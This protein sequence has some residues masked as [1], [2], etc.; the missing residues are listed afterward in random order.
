MKKLLISILL[1]PLLLLFAGCP[2]NTSFPLSQPGSEKINKALLGTWMNANPDSAEGDV[3]GVKISE[4]DKYTYTVE[5]LRKGAMYMADDSIFD[6]FVTSLEGKNF[7]YVRPA[8]HA[9]KYY[10]Y[11]YEFRNKQLSTYDVGLKIG[12]ID[13]VT[14]INAFQQEVRESLKREDCLSGEIKWRRTE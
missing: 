11:C 5:V 14:S 3:L 6:G 2:V 10:L 1:L 7:F 12:G 9:E 8:N 4:K 13:A